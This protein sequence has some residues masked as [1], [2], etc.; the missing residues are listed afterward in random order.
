MQETLVEL[1]AKNAINLE[2]AIKMGFVP[3]EEPEKQQ[4][5]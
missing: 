3:A 4:K 1:M 2:M 5:R